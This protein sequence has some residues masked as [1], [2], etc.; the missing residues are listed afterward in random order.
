MEHFMS[1]HTHHNVFLVLLSY[2]IAT[3]SAYA[4]I[5]LARRVKHS[6]KKE[7]LIWLIL[8]G[9]AL[10]IGIW[11]MHF[12]AMLAYHF[13]VPVYY[14]LFLVILS[15]IIAGIGCILGFLIVSGQSLPFLRFVLAGIIM[16]SGI[17]TMYYV[18]M[19]AIQPVIITYNDVLFS[20]SIFIAIFASMVAL[21]I[22]FFSPFSKKEMAWK[23]KLLFSIIMAFAITGMHYTGMSATNISGHATNLESY[24]SLLDTNLLAWIVV[25]GTALIFI[26]LFFSLSFD[27]MYKKHELVQSIILDSAVDGIAV[28]KDDGTI[29]HANPAF[30]QLMNSEENSTN[31][32]YLETYLST[33][34]QHFSFHQEYHLKKSNHIIEMKKHP[35][36]GEHLQQSLWFFR[37]ITEQVQAKERIE[38]LAFHDPLTQLPNRYK[39]EMEIKKQIDTNTELAC[40]FIDL[41]K[42]KFTNDTF[43]HNVGDSLLS[44]ASQRLA[45]ALEVGD[46]LSRIGGDEFVIILSGN[47]VKKVDDVVQK[48]MSEMEVPFTINGTKIRVTISAGVCAFPQE[49]K[50]VEELLRFSDLAMYESKRN[51]KN[52]V[53]YFNSLLSEKM[54]RVHLIEKEMIHAMQH[55][56]FHLLFQPKIQV[57]TGKVDSVEALIRWNHPELGFISPGEFI[58]IAEEKDLIWS[59]GTWVLRAACEQ[60]SEWKTK[61]MV[62]MKIAVN[63]SPLQFSKDDFLPMLTSILE[64]TGMNPKRLEL[65]ITES[66]SLAFEEQT[67]KKLKT[68]QHMGISISLD[69][70]GTGYSSFKHLKQLPIEVLKI[71]KSFVDHLIG[72]HDQESIV[73]SMIQLG[74]N[75]S[76]KVLVEGVEHKEQA[77][78]LAKE[79]C[80]M[81]QGYYFSKPIP[82]D[83]L[84][85][86]IIDQ[87]SKEVGVT[88]SNE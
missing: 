60:W 84:T 51:G 73:R 39:L 37:D 82:P 86:Y 17:A 58:P 79:G 9:A 72:N 49:A 50:N 24:S 48:C 3:I 41:D 16:G 59:I 18:G 66:S 47:R 36:I 46:L 8:G 35:I 10:G 13:P 34:T 19:E 31:K 2:L 7:K 6:K 27:R 32:D 53:T 75:L 54:R 88:F 12:I 5:D 11:S 40:I 85:K 43:G 29:I 65:E 20:I 14:H 81:I 4:S 74:H 22:G 15:V 45:H 33:S 56:D 30:Y 38:F 42:L 1:T 62:D 68:I 64:E 25:I 57:P 71:D 76:M 61:E 21:W 52:R 78:W 67:R 63:I 77:K 87:K 26:C 69:D 70:F 44:F 28:T 55:N 80:D 23:L 83:Q